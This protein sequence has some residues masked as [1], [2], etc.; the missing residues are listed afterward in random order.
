LWGGGGK[1]DLPLF[2]SQKRNR[3]EKL[4]WSWRGEKT[5]K[6]GNEGQGGS[7]ERSLNAILKPA[8]RENT[9][10]TPNAYR[11]GMHLS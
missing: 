1:K 10:R 4:P 9:L 11:T 3:E 6:G 7:K 8:R 5:C 2:P